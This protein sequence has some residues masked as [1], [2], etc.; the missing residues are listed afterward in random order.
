M[1]VQEEIKKTDIL[2][3]L[4]VIKTVCKKH[5]NCKTCPLRLD[6]VSS[7]CFLYCTPNPP[8]T[9]NLNYADNWRAFRG[10]ED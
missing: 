8:S 6:N 7:A 10:T 5:D 1:E 3:A 2:K 9:W 4:N